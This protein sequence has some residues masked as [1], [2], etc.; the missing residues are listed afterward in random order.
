MPHFSILG[1]RDS[2]R[3]SIDTYTF[4]EALE[5]AGFGC[6][7]WMLLFRTGWICAIE[8]SETLKMV[9][10]VPILKDVWNLH[11]W[12]CNMIGVSIFS[13]TIVGGVVVAKLS[14]IYGRRKIINCGTVLVAIFSLATGFTTSVSTFMI[15]CFLMSCTHTSV[16]ACTLL[17][18][19]SPKKWRARSMIMWQIFWM[20]GCIHTVLLSWLILPNFSLDL[21]WRMYIFASATT[22]SIVALGTLFVPESVRYLC[23]IGEGDT[24]TK[25]V[26]KMLQTNGAELMEGSLIRE[27]KVAVRGALTD[28][29]VDKYY[30]L[31]TIVLM[32]NYFV[33]GVVY[34]GVIFISEHLF[35][36]KSLYLS[37]LI[38]T[39][40]ELPAIPI[41]F[42]MDKTGRKGMMVITLIMNVIFASVA[43]V[44]WH[45]DMGDAQLKYPTVAITFCSRC[46]SH[47]FI[48]ALIAFINEY[49]P[50]AIRCSAYGFL[51]AIGRTGSLAGF[52]LWWDLDIVSG[53]SAI[54]ILC[55]FSLPFQFL[56]EDTSNKQLS[57]SVNKAHG[58]EELNSLSKEYNIKTY[59]IRQKLEELQKY[60]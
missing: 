5:L 4:D 20:M 7:Q 6:F 15:C 13:G 39:T 50:T 49:Y 25:V 56:L 12:E 10:L 44:L 53:L 27:K 37:E 42:L 28:L 58:Q 51:K 34:F 9:F 59:V 57:N 46:S 22:S 2:H 41:A 8:A 19:F 1:G 14:D 17:M 52:C 48:T 47:V 36:K 33:Y 23:T 11:M 32:L 35:M 40:S 29:F 43:A 30:R 21:G 3:K 18:E 26:E 38:V 55:L 31:T 45:F 24:A 16:V 60:W 54:A